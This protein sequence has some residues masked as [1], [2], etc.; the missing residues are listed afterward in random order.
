MAFALKSTVIPSNA[1]L[2]NLSDSDRRRQEKLAKV[3]SNILKTLALVSFCFVFC[4]AGNQ[5]W[6]FM[7]GLGYPLDFSSPFYTFSVFA[8]Y[9]NCSINP[10]IYIMKYEFC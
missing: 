6:F 7:F 4:W 9:V 10:F 1:P 5:I 3:R 2:D 8:V